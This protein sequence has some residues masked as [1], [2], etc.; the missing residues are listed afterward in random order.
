MLDHL[1]CSGILRRSLSGG[2]EFADIYFEEGNSTVIVCEDGK[3]EKV[4]AGADRG[5]GIRVISNLRTAYAYTNEI[6][7]ASLLSLAETVSR[8]I[9]GKAYD[10]VFDLRQKAVGKGFP[11]Q[12]PP[13][14]VSLQDKVATVARADR[15]AR[16]LDARTP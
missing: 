3:I 14:E 6:S 11:I 12:L 15:A 9:Q 16:G 10:S 7:E 4:I 5:A 1:D 2:G 8:A 13:A